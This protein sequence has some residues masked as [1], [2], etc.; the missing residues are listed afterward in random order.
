MAIAC[1][2]SAMKN[3]Q[4]QP[5]AQPR[6]ARMPEFDLL[7]RTFGGS[8]FELMHFMF[9]YTLF[10]PH[11]VLKNK[12]IF[13]FDAEADSV[14]AA[15]VQ[16]AWGVFRVE[17]YLEKEPPEGTLTAK[18]RSRGYSRTQWSNFYCDL[19]SSKEYV[20][21]FDSDVQL[22]QRPNSEDLFD[23]DA[24]PIIRMF[25]RDYNKAGAAAEYMV[26]RYYP[27]DSMLAFPFMVKTAH[28]PL[29]RRHV[30]QRVGGTFEQAWGSMQANFA[31]WGQF[32]VMTTYLWHFHHDEYA[33]RLLGDQDS[34]S[35]PDKDRAYIQSLFRP[36]A[37]IAKHLAMSTDSVAT[38]Q[39]Y[40]QQ[41]CA[42]SEF[43]AVDCNRDD[44]TDVT[45][46]EL[47]LLAPWTHFWPMENGHEM[48]SPELAR[49]NNN[50]ARVDWKALAHE[51]FALNWKEYGGE[52]AWRQTAYERSERTRDPCHR[53]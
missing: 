46:N 12:I 26:G 45:R 4:K 40:Y 10:W 30:A 34:E 13:V 43:R 9:T 48:F 39:S 20:G 25:A 42:Q 49:Q 19:Y 29:L 18:V 47:M 23:K 14:V 27:G 31:M 2:W 32:A 7:C 15:V 28:L 53:P 38:A 21:I 50:A 44:F 3:H 22:S 37:Q 35:W 51:S 17:V 16:A 24:K 11:E 52:A 6:Y 41:I 33:W 36:S 1:A 5:P 8:L